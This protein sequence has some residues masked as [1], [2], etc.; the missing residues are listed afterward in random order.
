MRSNSPSSP[1]YTPLPLQGSYV[2]LTGLH[3]EATMTTPRADRPFHPDCNTLE[4]RQTPSAAGLTQQLA[5]STPAAEASTTQVT[6]D[7]HSKDHH[8]L[9]DHVD[10]VYLGGGALG[11]GVRSLA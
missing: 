6:P 3:G 2:S 11:G 7:T 10:G 1:R 4:N 9:D 5:V 8:R